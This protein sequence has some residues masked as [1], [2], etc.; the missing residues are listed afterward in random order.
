MRFFAL[1]CLALPCLV[2][3]FALVCFALRCFADAAFSFCF[4]LLRFARCGRTDRLCCD[5]LFLP[6]FALLRTALFCFALLCF[7]GRRPGEPPGLCSA[8]LI[9]ICFALLCCAL[10][11]F[12]FA[13]V[14]FCFAGRRPR[15]PPGLRSTVLFCFCLFFFA[16]FCFALLCRL[17]LRE[18]P[19]L[20]HTARAKQSL[21]IIKKNRLLKKERLVFY[22]CFRLSQKE[23]S[24]RASAKKQIS[25]FRHTFLSD[26]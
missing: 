25:G 14:L 22:S 10:R 12:C 24:G 6:G 26:G 2:F 16:L 23:K 19:G 21:V 15:E 20:L 3:G 1:L 5:L 13:F 9:C 4:A 8:A 11:C 18:P 7:A 17:P